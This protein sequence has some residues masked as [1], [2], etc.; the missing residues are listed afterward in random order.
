MRQSKIPRSNVKE[1][2]NMFCKRYTY[3]ENIANIYRSQKHKAKLEIQKKKLHK[4]PSQWKI[5][6]VFQK[7]KKLSTENQQRYRGFENIINKLI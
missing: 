1:N 2:K 7:S 5:L 3:E 4:T 6:I